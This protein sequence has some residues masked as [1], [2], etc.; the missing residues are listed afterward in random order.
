MMTESNDTPKKLK[1]CAKCCM[2]VTSY[3]N[4]KSKIEHEKDEEKEVEDYWKVLNSLKVRE[5]NSIQRAIA[6]GEIEWDASR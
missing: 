2:P 3:V 6:A 1:R 4:R 5:K